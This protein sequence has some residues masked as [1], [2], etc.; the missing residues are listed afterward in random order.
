M[1]AKA[2]YAARG[3]KLA[4]ICAARTLVYGLL[5]FIHRAYRYLAPGAT[6][7]VGSVALSRGESHPSVGGWYI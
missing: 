3:R 1:Y 4:A 5:S 2:V 6:A 7:A